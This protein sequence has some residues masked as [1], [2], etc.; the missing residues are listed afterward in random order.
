MHHRHRKQSHLPMRQRLGIA[1]TS[2]FLVITISL[3]FSSKSF[4]AE[5]DCSPTQAISNLEAKQSYV[6][7]EEEKLAMAQVVYAEA[8]AESLRGQMAVAAVILNRFF[9]DDPYYRH[10]SILNLIRQPGQFARSSL[11]RD[12]IKK[13]S[14]GCIEAVELAIMGYDPTAEI[15]ENGALFYGA[16]WKHGVYGQTSI[17]QRSSDGATLMVI[18]RQAYRIVF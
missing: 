12:T 3:S 17:H 13:L 2:L 6:Y 5:A 7:S 4:A 11:S 15:F 10:D 1:I 14:P 8:N 16:D 9:G 18:D